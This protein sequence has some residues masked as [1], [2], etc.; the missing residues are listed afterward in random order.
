MSALLV[1]LL[2]PASDLRHCVVACGAADVAYGTWVK[3]HVTC[4][5]C[6]GARAPCTCTPTVPLC[7][8][9]RRW[10]RTHRA[11][12]SRRQA[13]LLPPIR[14]EAELQEEVRKA[15]AAGGWLYYHT[16]DSRKSPSGFP[17]TVCVRPGP[18]GAGARLVFAELKMPRTQPTDAQ[19]RWLTTLGQVREVR[20]FLWYPQ[21]LPTIWEVLQ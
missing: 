12:G 5:A 17:D 4:P 11:D 18:A 20:T 13:P 3:A 8:T 2:T 16:H 21:D 9:C 14:V 19:E 1:H 6:R 15:A 10:T 7:E